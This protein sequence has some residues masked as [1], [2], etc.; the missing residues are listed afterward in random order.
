[1]RGNLKKYNVQ[2]PVVTQ[3]DELISDK[4]LLSAAKHFKTILQQIILLFL[5]AIN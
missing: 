1:M 2:F 3:T 4:P 5:T